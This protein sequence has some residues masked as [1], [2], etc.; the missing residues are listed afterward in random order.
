M[1]ASQFIANALGEI[2]VVGLGQTPSG[3]AKTLALTILQRLVNSKG[4]E[5]LALYELLRTVKALTLGTRDYTIGTGGSINIVRPLWIDRAT[6]IQD[7]TATDPYEIPIGVYS[8]QDWQSVRQKTLDAAILYGV[9]FDHGLTSVASPV[10]TISTYPTISI[11]NTQVVLYTPKAVVAFVDAD[12]TDY[13]FPPGYEEAYHFELSYQLQ[14]P[15]GKP[16]DAELKTQRD[17]AWT[18]VYRTNVRPR[19]VGPDAG[20]PV[21]RRGVWNVKTMDYR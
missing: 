1:K 20:V 9:Y 17:D 14:R 7:S 8:E 11:A 4:A 12:V 13:A 6:F 16:A 2:G 19:I 18:R 15:F 21:G 10:G 5:R 3:E